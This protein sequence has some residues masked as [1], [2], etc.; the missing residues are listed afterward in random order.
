L[1]CIVQY[2]DNLQLVRAHLS[3][4]DDEGYAF[5]YEFTGIGNSTYSAR[6]WMSRQYDFYRLDNS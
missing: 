2:A 1:L 3:V 4:D 6:P 5:N